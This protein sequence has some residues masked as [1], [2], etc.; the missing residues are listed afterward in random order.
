MKYCLYYHIHSFS[1]NDASRK[2]QVTIVDDNTGEVFIGVARRH[3]AD[4]N[5]PIYGFEL[6]FTRALRQLADANLA[7][8]EACLIDEQLM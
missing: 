3:P 5:L 7:D 8:T 6:A 2:T 1:Y 4:H